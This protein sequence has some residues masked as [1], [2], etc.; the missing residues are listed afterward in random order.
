[1]NGKS[2]DDYI[3]MHEKTKQYLE[4]IREINQNDPKFLEKK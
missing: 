1:M 4:I 3:E 2:V